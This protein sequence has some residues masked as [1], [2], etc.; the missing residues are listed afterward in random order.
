MG[1]KQTRVL[2]IATQHLDVAWLWNR[3]P[4]GEELMRMV[5]ELALDSAARD[6]NAGFVM[7]RSTAWGFRTVEEKD[8]LLFRRVQRAVADGVIE[9]AGG[10]WVEPDNLIPSGES[11]IRQGLYG[12]TYYRARF[13]TTARVS[14]NPDVFGH[15]NSLPQIYRHVGLDGYYFHRMLPTDENGGAIGNFIWEGPDGAQVL[16]FA[17]NWIKRPDADGLE[18]VFET[19]P[20]PAIGTVAAVTGR[21]SDRRMTIT[22]DWL[23]LPARMKEELGLDECRWATSADMLRAVEEAR[24]RLPVVRGDLGG[25]S[26][27]G[28]YT[29]D[30]ITKRFNRRLENALAQAEFLE[31]WAGAAASRD[32]AGSTAAAPTTA[33]A[34]GDLSEAWR[35]LCLNQFHDIICGTCYRTAQEE[36]HALYRSIDLRVAA[37]IDRSA[38]VLAE[39]VGTDEQ[40]GAP[41]IA[42]NVSPVE[43]H[44]PIHVEVPRIGARPTGPL[45]V[46]D[47]EGRVVASQESPD[48]GLRVLPRSIPAYGYSVFYVQP[49]SERREVRDDELALE[50]D[51]LRVEFD[52]S[53]GNITSLYDKRTDTE[54]VAETGRFDR[55]VAYEDK[56]D[57]PASPDHRWDPWNIRYTGKEYDPH[58]AYTVFVAESG[59]VRK[60]IRVIRSFSATAAL[61]NTVLI[62][63]ISLSPG[64]PLLRIDMHGDWQAY[65]AMVKAEFDL[66]FSFESVVCEMPYGV[67]ERSSTIDTVRDVGAEAAEDRLLP[68]SK[69]DE[70]DRPMQNWVDVSDGERGIAFLNNGKYGYDS[71]PQ[72]VRLSLMRA[73]LMREGE[74][75][76]LG[77]FEF[78]YALFPHPGSW[79]DAGVPDVALAFNRDPIVKT[80]WAHS[81]EMPPSASL[82][83]V[84]DSAVHLTVVKHAE[85]SIGTVVRLYETTG[86]ERQVVLSS[87]YRLA[88]AWETNGLED[89]D[90]APEI[91]VGAGG[92]SLP[93]R[94]GAHE[95]KTVVLE[96]ASLR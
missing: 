2:V 1:S 85:R 52:P 77:P 44:Q 23:S 25:Y 42:W 27:T 62:R 24:E 14:W 39:R 87:A 75:A 4:H 56:N 31:V 66:S 37:S 7:S 19:A 51:L 83:S 41:A 86:R 64:S 34:A 6:P 35:D 94:I 20:G 63:D 13:G 46:V 93:L 30:Q 32:G 29:S 49:Q 5:L 67:I 91:P 8:P 40:A 79:Q 12:Q 15:G 80:T 10:Q 3:V 53:Y 22:P 11:Q 43:W 47:P 38:A 81:G 96:P 82:F 65:E 88:R 90:G 68:G 95:I 9:V 78:S 69:R 18:Q 21:S 60:T 26:Y 28:T 50:N 17:G 74:V 58:G 70:P 76:G 92:T 33:A 73:P 45:R 72:S 89:T 61:S 59:P 71:T 16:C 55:I 57:Y 84:S 36:A 54:Y 48:G